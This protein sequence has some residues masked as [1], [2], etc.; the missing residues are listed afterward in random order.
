MQLKEI[1]RKELV[2]A[3]PDLSIREAA[4]RMKDEKV[5]CVLVTED[6]SLKGILTDRDIACSVVAEGKDPSNTRVREIMKS[7]PAFSSPDTD[8]MEASRIMSEKKI[9][10]LPILAN[11]KLQGIVTTSDLASVLK[12]EMDNFLNVEEFYHL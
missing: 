11:G 4:K 1:M 9:R 6:G 5:G 12:K 8:I 7:S 3:K 2:T 10:R